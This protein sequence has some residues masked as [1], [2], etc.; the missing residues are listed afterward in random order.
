MDLASAWEDHARDWITW[1]RATGHDGFWHG[2]WPAFRAM[3]PP[4]TGLVIDLGSG[5]GRVCRELAGLGYRVVGV[6]RSATLTQAAKSASPSLAFARADAAA[7][8]FADGCAALVI[9]CMPLHDIDDLAGAVREAGRVLWPGGQLCIAVVHPFVTPQDDETLHTS[10]F[11]V[12]RPYLQPRRYE[13][14]VERDGLVMTF[15]SMHRPLRDYTSALSEN[16]FVISELA[17][18]GD[19]AVPWLLM[20]RAELHPRVVTAAPRRTDLPRRA[21]AVRRGRRARL[22]VQP[23]SLEV[24]PPAGIGG[25]AGRRCRGVSWCWRG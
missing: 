16:H 11:R 15:V 3:L 19:G 2:T 14:H 7:L 12:S 1:A 9:A 5:E 10:A 18:F 4:P 22:T 24:E 25:S 23:D 8:P 20:I 13:D 21:R 6:D 17:E